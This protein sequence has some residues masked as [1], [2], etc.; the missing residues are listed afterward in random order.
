MI[1]QKID[2]NENIG[3]YKKNTAI[4]P[5]MPRLILPKKSVDTNDFLYHYPILQKPSVSFGRKIEKATS[6][7]DSLTK[8]FTP[9]PEGLKHDKFQ[10]DSAKVIYEGNDALTIAPTGTGKTALIEYTIA[11]NIA[12][13]NETIVTFPTKA[14]SNEKYD[15]FCNLYGEENVGLLT[16]DTKLKT[17]APVKVM[18][19]EVYRNQLFSD[20]IS[21]K[22]A[23][24]VHDEIH[25]M[26]DPQRGKVNETIIM[27]TPA[28]VQQVLLSGTFENGKEFTDWLNRL[29]TIKNQAEMVDSPKKAVMVQMSQAERHVPLKYFIYDKESNKMI[30]LMTEKYNIAQLKQADK[31]GA[32]TE[33]QKGVLNEISNL[34]FEK[35][36]DQK[37][38]LEALSDLISSESDSLEKLEKDLIE[39]LGVEFTNAQRMAAFLSDPSERKYNS[40]GL[41]KFQKT[42]PK[43][44]R[45]LQD[46]SEVVKTGKKADTMD[47]ATV[48]KNLTMIL[49]RDD[50]LPAIGFKLS[51]TACDEMQEVTGAI[52]LLSKDEKEEVSKLIEA[53]RAKNYIGADDKAVELLKSGSGVHHAGKMPGFK[54]MVEELSQKF[55]KLVW[56]TSSL[57]TGIDV[58]AK[59]VIITQL[60]RQVGKDAQR[61]PIYENFTINEIIQM[62]GRAGRRG[63]D[64]IGN[65]VFM[66]D[67]RHSP[68]DI[69]KIVTSKPDPIESRLTPEYNL[70]SRC[71]EVDGSDKGFDDVVERSFLTE[72]LQGKS[73][74]PEKRLNA[75]KDDLRSFAAVLQEPELEC[76]SKEEKIVG[77]NITYPKGLTTKEDILVPTLKGSVIKKAMG[78]DGLLFAEMLFKAPLETLKPSHLAALACYLTEGS[79]KNESFKIE[80]LKKPS[81]E[82]IKNKPKNKSRERVN[83]VKLDEP[84]TEIVGNIEEIKFGIRVLEKKHK[85]HKI[86]VPSNIIDMKFVQEWAEST[87]ENATESWKKLAG[88][89]DEGDRFKSVTGAADILK[90]I[91]E[92]AEYVAD[93]SVSEEQAE[94]KTKMDTIAKNASKAWE[95]LKKGPIPHLE[96]SLRV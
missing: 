2:N 64:L 26:N 25:T 77:L 50:K 78:M 1:V 35:Y 24:V 87:G 74:N 96:K 61:K 56:A 4:F 27:Y 15:R 82:V 52:P 38:G 46:I 9:L 67:E 44:G 51:K 48:L 3:F 69:Y 55:L 28:R 76:F 12:E 42:E 30:P 73:I 89:F 94:I 81:T 70:V 71:L 54:K 93:K 13:G 66:P 63:K 65:V 6:F 84:L 14:L 10:I 43:I 68:E 21:P 41:A 86:E 8:Y 83:S 39:N 53:A 49:N 62:I 57:G 91:Q 29:Q 32:L 16:G 19:T 59:T 20:T 22:L 36:D 92:A 75:L 90:Q 88:H 34:V 80:S 37:S 7:E 95:M 79:Y 47:E 5:A 45:S 72:Q 40:A 18:T 17:G 33:K 60:D 11:K 58:P 85:I 23:S 31:K